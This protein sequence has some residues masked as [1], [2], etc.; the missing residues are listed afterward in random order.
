MCKAILDTC[1]LN[2]FNREAKIPD[3]FYKLMGEA[4]FELLIHPYVFTNELSVQ[5]YAKTLI[6]NGTCKLVNYDD[7][8]MSDYYKAYYSGLFIQVYNEF[9][10]YLKSTDSNKADKM[11]ALGI[12]TDVFEYRRAGASIGDVHMILMAFFMEIPI[13]LSE[14]SDLAMIYKIAVKHINNQH[15]QLLVYNVNDVIEYIK[16]SDNRT[17]SN[18]DLKHIRRYTN[19]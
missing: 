6:D 2:K 18:K 14:D 5:S 4:G 11:S 12:D 7:F 13:I 3:E 10:E 16:N 15:Y 1:F 19:W 17:I 9:Y 8:I